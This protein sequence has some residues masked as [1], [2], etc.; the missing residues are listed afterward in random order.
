[1]KRERVSARESRQRSANE[2]VSGLGEKESHRRV[3]AEQSTHRERDRQT[4]R[5][6]ERTKGDS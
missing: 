1:M 2:T 3:H 6:R 5:E 4:E